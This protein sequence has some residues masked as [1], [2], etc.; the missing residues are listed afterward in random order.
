MLFDFRITLDTLYQLN[1]FLN[2]VLISAVIVDEPIQFY[3][4]GFVDHRIGKQQIALHVSIDGRMHYAQKNRRI[5][6]LRINNRL[7]ES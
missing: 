2:T 5:I 4:D 1:Y 3:E 6:Y 7:M